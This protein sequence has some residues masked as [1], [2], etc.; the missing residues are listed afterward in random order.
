MNEEQGVG[1]PDPVW[2]VHPLGVSGFRGLATCGV[3][4]H[5]ASC[6]ICSSLGR[7]RQRDDFI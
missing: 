2:T 4:T 1:T 6:D 3:H 7:L 5:G